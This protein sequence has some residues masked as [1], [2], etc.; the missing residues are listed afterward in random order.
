MAIQYSIFLVRNSISMCIFPTLYT[1]SNSEK[2]RF[3]SIRV[4]E[5]PDDSAI[6]NVKYGEIGGKITKPK[7]NNYNKKYW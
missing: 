4:T 6:T 5:L 3:W 2:Q 7:R 1:I